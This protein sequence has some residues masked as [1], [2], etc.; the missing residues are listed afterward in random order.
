MGFIM[1]D[2]FTKLNLFVCGCVLSLIFMLAFFNSV[3]AADEATS[4]P[5]LPTLAES[6]ATV[7]SFFADDP[8]MI[9]IAKCESSFRQF[10]DDG[11][12]LKGHG[13]YVGVFQIAEKIHAAAAKEIGM[14][15][16]TL[17]GNLAYA[18]YL[19]NL[20]GSKLWPTC[21]RISVGATT[22]TKNLKI[23]DTNSQVKFLQQLL[24][25]AGFAVAKSGSGSAGQET[26][27]FGAM[28]KTAVRKFQCAKKIICQGSEATTGYGAVGPKTR[29][30]LLATQAN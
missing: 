19:K 2:E 1:K 28:T 17:E 10:N 24:N 4:T 26:T 16:Y 21:A 7:R 3:L 13:L 20:H 5:A 25:N 14:D 30:V 9:A 23:G 15:I 22:L 11:T 8:I 18:K 29:A 27:F 6:E 12:V